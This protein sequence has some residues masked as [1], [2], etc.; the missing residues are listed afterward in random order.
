[1][2]KI[3]VSSTSGV[4]AALTLIKSEQIKL[5]GRSVLFGRR[6]LV[7]DV[8]SGLGQLPGQLS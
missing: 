8:L 6:R 7:I 2:L 5:I 1:M 4:M 3:L